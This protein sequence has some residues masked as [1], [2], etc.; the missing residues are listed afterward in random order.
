[1][2]FLF[3]LCVYWLAINQRM[4]VQWGQTI[5]L[6]QHTHIQNIADVHTNHLSIYHD[7]FA[8]KIYCLANGERWDFISFA[9]VTASTTALSSAKCMV[10]LVFFP[11]MVNLLFLPSILNCRMQS[12]LNLKVWWLPIANVWNTIFAP[13]NWQAFS[14][15]CFLYSFQQFDWRTETFFV[16]FV[17]VVAIS[18]KKCGHTDFHH[19]LLYDE[20]VVFFPIVRCGKIAL[21]LSNVDVSII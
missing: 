17:V 12:W 4:Y 1:M 19:T 3:A 14:S 5:R 6:D 15:I 16:F 13:Q 9:L 7:L 2:V 18:I 21:L 10:D 8:N 11:L 20:C